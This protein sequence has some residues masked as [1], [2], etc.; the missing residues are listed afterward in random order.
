MLKKSSSILNISRNCHSFFPHFFSLSHAF[1]AQLS[2]RFLLPFWSLC[3][4][5]NI[6]NILKRIRKVNKPFCRTPAVVI[7]ARA[8][9]FTLQDKFI[10]VEGR[11]S[12][13]LTISRSSVSFL[14]ALKP[15]F[16]L[17]NSCA[18]REV[19]STLTVWL[20]VMKLSSA[21]PGI[22][23]VTHW[24]KLQNMRIKYLRWNTYTVYNYFKWK[25][26]RIIILTINSSRMKYRN[27]FTGI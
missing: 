3:R 22:D 6:T 12:Y 17:I 9:L 18:S 27:I 26:D 13:S 19:V 24:R 8:Q 2:H 25:L 15:D 14:L 20:I 11:I 1:S 16:Y 10:K 23:F 5:P 21:R 7:S 4:V